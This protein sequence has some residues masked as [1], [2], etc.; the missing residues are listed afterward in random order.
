[1]SSATQGQGARHPI[2]ADGVAVRGGDTLWDDDLK[3]H[4]VVELLPDRWAHP[5]VKAREECGNVWHAEAGC[6]F[7]SREAA[8]A[9]IVAD[10]GDTA[11]AAME[12]LSNAYRRLA[13]AE[14]NLCLVRRGLDPIGEDEEPDDR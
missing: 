11:E 9:K 6:L 14:I 2:T 1:M 7:S 5:Q 13:R 12:H 3:P 4:V 10:A 8:A